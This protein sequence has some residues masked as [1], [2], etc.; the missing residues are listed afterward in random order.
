[1][2]FESQTLSL[3]K[4]YWP[5]AYY[6]LERRSKLQTR[7]TMRPNSVS[8]THVLSVAEEMT[9]HAAH[10][11]YYCPA[12]SWFE[13]LEVCPTHIHSKPQFYLMNSKK[14]VFFTA[15]QL[16]RRP[17][18]TRQHVP[19]NGPAQGFTRRQVLGSCVMCPRIGISFG[20]FRVL[21]EP[22]CLRA[23]TTATSYGAS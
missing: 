17:K 6:E 13:T 15:F 14:T 2:N 22:L 1:M 18:H 9:V 4:R 23:R 12:I 20:R 10:L 16:H 11:S 19:P 3:R 21:K 5:D 8:L 7:E